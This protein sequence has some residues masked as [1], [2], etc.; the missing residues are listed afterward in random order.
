MTEPY[1]AGILG[2]S[3]SLTN[4]ARLALPADHRIVAVRDDPDCLMTFWLIEGRSMPIVEPGATPPDVR[5]H[6]SLGNDDAGV[7]LSAWWEHGGEPIAWRVGD[8]PTFAAF[9]AE[10]TADGA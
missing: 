6:L 7:H 2:V 4:R 1:R 5:L 10:F 8:W 3:A 9:R